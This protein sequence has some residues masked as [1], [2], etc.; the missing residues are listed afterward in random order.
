MINKKVGQAFIKR[1]SIQKKKGKDQRKI[2]GFFDNSVLMSG[3]KQAAKDKN[4]NKIGIELQ[5]SEQLS[6]LKSAFDT[7]SKK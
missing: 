1:N 5:N 6:D 3:N 2:S 7:I 4:E